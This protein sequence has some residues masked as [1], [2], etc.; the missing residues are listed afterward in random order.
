MPC[1]AVPPARTVAGVVRGRRPVRPL[2]GAAEAEEITIAAAEE[3]VRVVETAD[4]VV[5]QQYVH[6]TVCAGM[7]V[8][9]CR[10]APAVSLR[11][12]ILPPKCC[13]GGRGGHSGYR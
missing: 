11:K 12:R 9:V 1:A 4:E 3:P 10:S 7:G 6:A 5:I 13:V 2:P 8:F